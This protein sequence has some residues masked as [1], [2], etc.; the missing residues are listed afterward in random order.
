MVLLTPTINNSDNAEH[1]WCGCLA[2]VV[3]SLNTNGADHKKLTKC[4]GKQF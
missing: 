2:H 4:Y 1:K 3:W